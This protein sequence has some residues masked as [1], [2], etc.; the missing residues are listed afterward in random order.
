M[1][2]Q[3][4]LKDIKFLIANWF[5]ALEDEGCDPWE[6]EECMSMANKYGYTKEDYKNYCRTIY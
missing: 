3:E 6:N 1:T 4:V 5:L 2:K